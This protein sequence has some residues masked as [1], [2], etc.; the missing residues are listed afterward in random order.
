MKDVV[1]DVLLFYLFST[2]HQGFPTLPMAAARL[3]LPLPSAFQT[4][5]LLYI[6]VSSLSKHHRSLGQYFNDEKWKIEFVSIQLFSLQIF[7]CYGFI[8]FSSVWG[9]ALQCSHYPCFESF[10]SIC[11]TRIIPPSNLIDL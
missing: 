5:Q 6:A 10:E 8:F 9:G 1:K 3:T 7:S 11:C 4:L 2:F